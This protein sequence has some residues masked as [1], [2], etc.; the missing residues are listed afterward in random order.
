MATDKTAKMFKVFVF[1]EA[2]MEDFV[3]EKNE[4]IPPIY[5]DCIEL[6]MLYESLIVD[7]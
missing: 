2:G 7:I 3:F 6:F 5:T 4:V 1:D